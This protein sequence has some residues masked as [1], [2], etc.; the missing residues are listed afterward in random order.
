M[1]TGSRVKIGIFFLVRGTLLILINNVLVKCYCEVFLC[2]NET[3]HECYSLLF[4]TDS[5]LQ[6]MSCVLRREDTDLKV[7]RTR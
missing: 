3:L 5:C 7:S 4:N 6:E 1:K 2:E